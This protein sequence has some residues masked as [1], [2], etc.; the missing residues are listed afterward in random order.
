MKNKF[1]LLLLAMLCTST[2]VFTACSNDDDDN[3]TYLDNGKLTIDSPAEF[4]VGPSREMSMVV[5][6]GS[7]DYSVTSSDESILQVLGVSSGKVIRIKAIK[8]GT[9]TLTVYDNKNKQELKYQV[10]VEPTP[11]GIDYAGSP[12]VYTTGADGTI[13]IPLSGEFLASEIQITNPSSNLTAT[14]VDVASGIAVR[15]SGTA[16]ASEKVNI[17]IAAG[18]ESFPLDVVLA[19]RITFADDVETATIAADMPF[20][21]LITDSNSTNF[22]ISNDNSTAVDVKVESGVLKVTPLLKTAGTYEVT[23][24]DEFASQTYTINI[25]VTP[26][27]ALNSYDITMTQ[28]EFGANHTDNNNGLYLA[29]KYGTPDSMPW[30]YMNT[31]SVIYSDTYADPTD[32]GAVKNILKISSRL[33][34]R[35]NGASIILNMK[36]IPYIGGVA[37][38]GIDDPTTNVPVGNCKIQTSDGTSTRVINFTIIAG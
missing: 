2:F 24:G 21:T 9:V 32:G 14:A 1:L 31:S 6:S 15:L 8:R 11:L 29:Y 5:R 37:R 28:T 18:S 3:K 20:E 13:E 36:T 30:G 17:R 12:I 16:N 19:K 4:K 23:I 25:A 35:F 33:F 38:N 34:P 27:W 22:V 26:D 10:E 7:G